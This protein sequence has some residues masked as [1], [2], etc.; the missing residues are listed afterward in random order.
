MDATDIVPISD[1]ARAE[2]E[3]LQKAT[4]AA[5]AR[6]DRCRIEEVA[7]GNARRYLVH[8]FR[9]AGSGSPKKIIL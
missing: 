9:R 3:A 1:E 7:Q 5:L 8:N 6:D 2:Y 4:D